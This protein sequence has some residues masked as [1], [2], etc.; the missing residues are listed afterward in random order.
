[1]NFGEWVTVAI[2]VFGLLAFAVWM[3]RI[4][5]RALDACLEAGA[6]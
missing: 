4:H 5:V 6:E 3:V 1:L 2:M